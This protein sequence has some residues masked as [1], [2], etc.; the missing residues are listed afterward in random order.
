M[1]VVA[2]IHWKFRRPVLA[3]LLAFAS[4]SW[5]NEHNWGIETEVLQPGFPGVGMFRLTG[6]RRVWGAAGVLRGDL[7]VGVRYRR[8]VADTVSSTVTEVLGSVGYRQYFWRGLLL[9][10]HVTAGLVSGTNRIDGMARSNFGMAGSLLAG[11]RFGFFEPG[12]FFD[13]TSAVGFFIIPQVGVFRVL[14]LDSLGPRGSASATAF[15]AA[16]QLGVSF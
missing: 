12:G 4:P 15:E 2:S 6:G 11:Y 5:A 13:T 16:V 8:P 3:V 7:M 1:H 9:E 10:L 14:T